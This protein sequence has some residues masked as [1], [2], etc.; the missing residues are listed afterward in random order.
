M[1]KQDNAVF[2]IKVHIEYG[3]DWK[4]AET[5]DTCSNINIYNVTADNTC[6][7]VWMIINQVIDSSWDM[8]CYMREQIL[9]HI[10][11]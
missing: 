5:D 11:W 9:K 6:K 4:I 3:E 7:I 8:Q 1:K 2:D 10:T